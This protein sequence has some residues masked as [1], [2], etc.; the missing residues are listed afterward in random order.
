MSDQVIEKVPRDKAS[1]IITNG[2]ISEAVWFMAAPTIIN[3]LVYAAY[4]IINRFFMGHIPGDSAP[5]MAALGIGQVWLMIQQAIMFGICT[6][7]SAL[8]SRFLGS[9][10]V[11][12]AQKA[13]GQSMALTTIVAIITLL[14]L[15]IW[16]LPA[17]R[18]AGAK[19]ESAYLAADYLRIIA[20]YGSVPMF[21]RTT[22]LIA[23]R[24][25]GDAKSPLYTG[26]VIVVV[27][28]LVDWLLIWG[29]GPFPAMG[30]RGAAIGT[31]VSQF[32]GLI[33]VMHFLKRSV[34]DGAV[35]RMQPHMGWYARILRI[36]Y[37]AIIQNVLWSVGFAMLVWV[38]GKL[39]DSIDAQAA[40][41]AQAALTIAYPI[42]MIAFMPGNAYGIAAT[43]LVGQNLG[44]GKPKRAEHCALVATVHAVA[45]MSAIAVVY[46]T[47][48]KLLAEFFTN[49]KPVV[50]GVVSYLRINAIAEPFLAVAMVL[51]GALQGAG[52]TLTPMIIELFASIII[53]LP[54]AWFLSVHMDLGV[55]GVWIALASTTMLYGITIGLWF[56]TGRWKLR[57]V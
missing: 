18:L 49:S 7:S 44:A 41:H 34:L 36:G 10:D 5:S 42:E 56:K 50:A 51:T 21:L 2:R 27:N 57:R 8:S 33:V 52:D 4:N 17:V 48:P 9:E 45:I 20:F 6:G 35:R 14:P 3:M 37:P 30:V 28:I 32:A 53:R 46:L 26:I 24:S 13:V 55:L 31:V 22:V 19:P 29:P 12:S 40:T 47:V 11:R 1:E 15:S 39:P 38:L 23:L 25:A 43:P 54:L 16:A